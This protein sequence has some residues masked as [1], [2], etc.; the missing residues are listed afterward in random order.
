[1]KQPKVKVNGKEVDV[2][3]VNFFQSDGSISHV[4][5][6]DGDDLILAFK[7]NSSPFWDDANGRHLEVEFIEE[8]VQ[9][10]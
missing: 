4:G 1:M 3:S 7:N 9:H 6:Y 5:Y 8:E 10:A 2:V